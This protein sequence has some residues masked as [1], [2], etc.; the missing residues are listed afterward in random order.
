M[1]RDGSDLRRLT[2]NPGIDITPTWSPSGTQ[3]AFTSD[4]SGTPQIY[5]VGADG[6]E[7]VEEDLRSRTATG[8]RGRRR[9]STRSRSRRAAARA[10]TSGCSTSSTGVAKS[11]TF[12]ERHATKARRSRR[13]AGTS[14]SPRRAPARRRCSRWRATARTCGRLRRAGNNYEAGLVQMTGESTMKAARSI[15]AAGRGRGAAHRGRLRQK[16]AAGRASD[17]A[18]AAA[19]RAPRRRSRRLRPSRSREPIGRAARTGARRRDLVGVAR[20]SEQ[21]LAAEAGLLRAGQQ[22]V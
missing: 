7:P 21:E 1:N 10:S 8:R 9:R 15:A 22:R 13:T 5:V 2:N 12:G 16:N 3:I 6:A 11:L 4:R 19:G 17:A 18:A 14:C 20:R